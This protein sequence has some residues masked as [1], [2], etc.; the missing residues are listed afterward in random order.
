MPTHKTTIVAKKYPHEL[1]QKQWKHLR[2][3]LPLPIKKTGGPGRKPLDLREVL[4]AILYV[5][6]SGCSWSML[7]NDYPPCQKC[8]PL[9][10]SV[11]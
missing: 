3:L 10:Q 4:N 1:S 5:M 6:P 9:F 8:L 7:P 11:E 2:K